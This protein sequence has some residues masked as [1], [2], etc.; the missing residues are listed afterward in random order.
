MFW[1]LAVFLWVN[2]E[3]PIE[4]GKKDLQLWRFSNI[5]N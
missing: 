1:Q 4:K 2:R 5:I 3:K